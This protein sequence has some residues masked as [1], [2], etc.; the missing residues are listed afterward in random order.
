MSIDETKKYYDENSLKEWNRL[1]VHPF[2]FVFTTHIMD[3]YIKPTHSILDIGGGPGR[4]SINY[5]KKGCDVTLIDLSDGNIQLAKDKAKEQNLEFP[6]FVSN[7]LNIGDM[8]LKKYDHVFLMGPLYHL[9]DMEDRIKAV[10]LAIER[11]KPGGILYCSFILDFAGIIYD[12]KNGP[13]FLPEDLGN[14]STKKLIDSITTG[15]EYSGPAFTS[16]FFINQKQIEPFMNKFNLEKL[17]L[18]G[19][20]GILALNENQIKTFPKEEFDLWIETSKKF[21]DIPE[22]LAFSE[23]AMYVGKKPI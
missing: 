2:E 6:M 12:L 22:F 14:Q 16:A 5:A 21:L 8:E 9:L 23:H 17:H 3:K 11:L 1:N 13:G 18:F 20:E 10:N 19:Q 4:Y 15:T 7:C